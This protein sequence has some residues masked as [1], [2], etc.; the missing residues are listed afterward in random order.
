MNPSTRAERGGGFK[1]LKDGL[2]QV[3]LAPGREKRPSRADGEQTGCPFCPGN[4]HLT[5]PTLYQIPKDNER[6]HIRVFENL[7]PLFSA[8]KKS[9]AYGIHEMVV[10][11]PKHESMLRELPVKDISLV[12]QT[13]RERMR[14]LSQDERLETVLAFRNQGLRGGASLAHPHTQLVGLSWIPPRLAAERDQFLDLA[15]KGS[16][17]LC[18]SA[19][20]PLI[21]LEQDSFRAFSPSAPRFPYETWIAPVHHEPSFANLKDGE[22]DDL[23]AV[24]RKVLSG[25]AKLGNE[26]GKP[27]CYN[28]VVHT[29]PLNDESGTFHL[30]LEV[31]P[32]FEALAGFELGTGTWV[33]TVEPEESAIGLRKAIL[34]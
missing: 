3:L 30:H 16:C 4:E 32:R 1:V 6:W 19:S 23:A 15:D 13:I 9:Q 34:G 22:A 20:D 26:A 28:L 11:T 10:E 29:E 21:I 17:P 33:T 24:L 31:M 5:P 7:Y 27:F 8:D 25:M 14:H 18:M 12:M 2:T